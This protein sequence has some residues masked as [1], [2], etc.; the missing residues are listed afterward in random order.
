MTYNLRYDNPNDGENKWD[1]RKNILSHQI[2]F[3]NPD[4][5]GTQE[6]KLH[7]LQYLDSTLTEYNYIGIGR[8]NSPNQ[9]E[10]SAIFYNKNKFKVIKQSTFWLSETPDKVSKGWDANLE[11]ICTYALFEDVKTNQKFYV[12]NTHF[13][14]IGETARTNSALL[15]IKKINEINKQNDP[16]VLTGDLNSEPDSKAYLYLSSQLN[17]SRKIS[18]SEPFGPEGTFNNFEFHKPVTLLIDY[19]FTSKKN[20]EVLKF[21]VLSDSKN[22]KYPSDHL[23]V[24]VEFLIQD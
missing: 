12:F 5:F 2:L 6:G 10:F 15:I 13:D 9:G 19:I 8:D 1:L 20:I 11:R 4:I 22:C 23:P 21:A 3:Y 18:K 14:H 24:Y 16:V 7:Q 17:D